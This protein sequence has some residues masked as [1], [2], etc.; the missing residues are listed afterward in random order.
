MS[1]SR[2]LTWAKVYVKML[3]LPHF[4]CDKSHNSLFGKKLQIKA[5]DHIPQHRG[6][7]EYVDWKELHTMLL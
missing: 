6:C 2:Y 4:L 3:A 7:Y 1:W 5:G